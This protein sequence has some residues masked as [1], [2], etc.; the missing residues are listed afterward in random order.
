M[1]SEIFEGSVHAADPGK[2]SWLE[3]EFGNNGDPSFRS[4]TMNN[5]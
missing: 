1:K 4:E 3:F 5:E 2:I